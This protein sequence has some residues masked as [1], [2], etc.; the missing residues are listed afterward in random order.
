M[1]ILMDIR[2][3]TPY[4]TTS[5]KRTHTKKI[6]SSSYISLITTSARPYTLALTIA[7]SWPLW[8]AKLISAKACPGELKNIYGPKPWWDLL[9]FPSRDPSI[10]WPFGFT[11]ALKNLHILQLYTI[12]SCNSK[13]DQLLSAIAN[14]Q[15]LWGSSTLLLSLTLNNFS[16]LAFPY[17]S[18]FCLSVTN[19]LISS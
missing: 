2:M 9:R 3:T 5:P 11:M 13:M 19:I 10:L 14:S 16:S 8:E 7:N 12:S 6:L 1:N 18:T 15:A 4:P 17:L